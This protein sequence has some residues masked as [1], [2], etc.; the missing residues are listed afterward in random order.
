MTF[1]TR[2]KKTEEIKQYLEIKL[3]KGFTQKSPNKIYILTILLGFIFSLL[4][5]YF[6]IIDTQKTQ[7]DNIIRQTQFYNI[8][9]KKHIEDFSNEQSQKLIMLAH[10]KELQEFITNSHK[11]APLEQLFFNIAKSDYHIMQIRYIDKT[12]VEKARVDQM[13]DLS[14]T[15]IS[16]DKLQNKLDRYYVQEF[17]KLPK[18]KIGFSKFDLNI[19]HGQ[20]E[21]PFRP[22]L[23]LGTAVYKKNKLQGIVI[24]NYYMSDWLTHFSKAFPYKIMLLNKENYFMYHYDKQWE[25]SK[26]QTLSKKASQFPLITNMPN[27]QKETKPY[28]LL[29]ESLIGIK[30]NLFQNDT[31]IIYN[32]QY[33]LQQQLTKTALKYTIY[34]LSAFIVGL[35]P[36]IFLLR[37]YVLIVRRNAKYLNALIENIFDPLLVI[38]QKGI[39]QYTNANASELFGYTTAEFRN[40]NINMI[41]PAPHHDQHDQYLANY[42]TE[43]RTVLGHNR[44]LHAITKDK[45]LI[46]VSIAVTKASIEGKVYFVG[47]IRD[48]R[49]I[50]ALELQNKKQ[51]ELLQ[52]QSKLAAMGEMIG[53][54][55]HQWRQPLNELSIRVQKLKYAFMKEQIDENYINNFIEKNKTTIEF[56]S[57]TIDDFRNFFRIDKEKRKFDILTTI[58]ETL[59]LQNA[60]LQ[61]HHISTTV[62]GDTFSVYGFQR[63]FQQVLLNIFSNAKDKFIEKHIRDPHITIK[64]NKGNITIQDNGGG[65]DKEVLPRVFEP[66]FTTKEQGSGTG[67]G[68]Y[69][70]KIIIEDNM[71]GK[72]SIANKDDGVMLSIVLKYSNENKEI[73]HG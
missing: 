9:I 50:K 62:E 34:I 70:A 25:W 20:I 39:I 13:K 24:I 49:D 42:T 68:L 27:W 52:Q 66:Y 22:T 32:M 17:L 30:T 72:I 61:N 64:L 47:V 60:Q 55:A 41:V 48:L 2:Q 53:A 16:E 15:V 7:Q 71:Q 26:Y 45:E 69:L 31:L 33:S 57:H 73:A 4:I 43:H 65:I 58:E 12:G 54:I 6:L 46:P 10:S 29:G 35:I 8:S 56:M 11:H 67:M 19:E 44:T 3:M 37:S 1:F 38:D 18:D 23:R 63:E 28:Y 5:I 14:A 21:R 36:I 40:Q 51:T 59:K